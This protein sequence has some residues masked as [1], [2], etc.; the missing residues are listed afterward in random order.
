MGPMAPFY[1]NFLCCPGFVK[2]NILVEKFI[3]LYIFIQPNFVY[4]I[5]FFE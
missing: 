3:I 1:E 2:S 5:Y 4:L